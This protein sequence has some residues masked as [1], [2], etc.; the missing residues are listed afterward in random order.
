MEQINLENLYS[1]LAFFNC[2]LNTEKGV[3]VL[4][5]RWLGRKMPG[6]YVSV[7]QRYLLQA[8]IHESLTL[9]FELGQ[10]RQ[11]ATSSRKP[12]LYKSSSVFS[13]R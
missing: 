4:Q 3:R 6:T 9:L 12:T 5:A 13:I 8:I 2:K 10:Q 11:P 1:F 7:W